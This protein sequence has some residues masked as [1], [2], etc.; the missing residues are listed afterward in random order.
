MRGT[1]T[2]RFSDD[3]FSTPLAILQYGISEGS[4]RPQGAKELEPGNFFFF[5]FFQAMQLT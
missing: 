3:V 2:I 4:L 1:G 5:W